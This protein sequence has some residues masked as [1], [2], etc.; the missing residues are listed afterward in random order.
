MINTYLDENQ[1]YFI[2]DEQHLCCDE[3]Q[4]KYVCKAHG[5]TMGCYYCEFDYS[6]E[7]EC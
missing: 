6:Q 4:F 7:C 2:K 5:E 3:L 1:F